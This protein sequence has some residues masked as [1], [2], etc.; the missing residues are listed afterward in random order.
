MNRPMS[1]KEIESI[2]NNLP[3]QK[4]PGPDRFTGEFYQIKKQIIPILFQKVEAEGI[5]PILLYEAR[6]TLISKLDKDIS[7]KLKTNIS[8]EHRCKSP[9]HITKLNPTM[10][11]KNNS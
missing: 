8:H 10:Y 6:V 5:L 11:I 9:Q 4:A 2:I 7:G 1:I 3:K